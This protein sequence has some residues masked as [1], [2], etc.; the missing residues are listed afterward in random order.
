MRSVIRRRLTSG[1]SLFLFLFLLLVLALDRPAAQVAG[2]N[3][4]MVTGGTFPGGDPFR[5]KNNEGSGAPSTR[6]PCHLL[7]GANDYRAV[8]LPGLPGDQEIGDAWVGWYESTDCGATWYSTLV[9]G[10]PQDN[11]PQGLASPMK[12]LSAAADPVVRSGAAGTFYYLFIAFNRGSNVGKLG[13]ARGIDHNDRETFIDP[14]KL[15][16][17]PNGVT[18]PRKP[19]SPIRYVDTTE[20]ARGSSAQ[21]IDKPNLAVFPAATGTCLMDGETVPATNVYVTWT[22]FIGNSAESQRSKIYFARSADCGRTLAGPATKLSEGYPLGQ[23]TAIGVN[24]TNPNDIY[25][26]WRQ[27]RNDRVRDALLFVRSTDGGRSFTKA[28]PIPGLGEGQYAPFDQRT[29]ST[30]LGNQTT[31]FRTTG[32]PA[33][34]F[35]DDGYL[36]LAVSQV[37][38][39]PGGGLGGA[40]ARITM[41]RTNGATWEPPVPILPTAGAAGQQFMPAL[42]YAAGRLQLTWYDVRFDESGQTTRPLIDEAQALATTRIRRT[43][44]VLGAQALLSVPPSWPPAFQLY[45]VSQPDYNDAPNGVRPLR[46]PRVSQYPVGDPLPG[47]VQGAGPRQLQ[48]NRGNLLIYGGGSIPF[49]SDY[50]DVNGIQFVLDPASGRWVFN[51]MANKDNAALGTFHAVWTDNRDVTVGKASTTADGRLN[52]APPLPLPPGSTVA[53]V[54][55]PAGVD[56]TGTRD[57]NVYTSRITQDFSFTVPGNTKPGNTVRAFAVQLSNNL[58][59]TPGTTTPETPTRFRLTLAASAAASFSRRS[60]LGCGQATGPVVR[61]SSSISTLDH[62]LHGPSTSPVAPDEQ[63]SRRRASS[64]TARMGHRHPWRSTATRRTLARRTPTVTRFRRR[65][66]RM[67]RIP[68]PRTPMPRIRMR[69]TRTPRI[70]TPRTRMPRIRTPKIL[71]PRTRMP[72]IRTPKIPTPRTRMPRTP[73]SR[74]SRWISPM[75]VTRPPDIRCRRRPRRSPMATRSC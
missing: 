41:T 72:R 54:S 59:L 30:V 34:A 8:H 33:L 71:T 36:Y 64:R 10:Y 23:G 6:N 40:D 69:K 26:V 7:A 25:V 53:D 3:V 75:T 55:C 58:E 62:R 42:A 46:G 38:G 27:I 4:N 56:D 12:G 22:E 5:Q 31:T 13:L 1:F 18:D 19:L 39:G 14:D 57:A 29:T 16:I 21:F 50:I 43:I 74:T 44:D 49:M 68:T 20:I 61:E 35:A 65:T 32:Y 15:V 67:R 73:P 63:W 28:E 11:S 45:G 9:P 60:F 17:S 51:G 2:R 47:S 52:Y 70:L 37:P 48:F 24:P 66:R